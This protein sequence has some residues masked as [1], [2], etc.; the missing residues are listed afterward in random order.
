MYTDLLNIFLSS[1]SRM[2][3]FKILC[4]SK[5]HIFVICPKH[6]LLKE[7]NLPLIEK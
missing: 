2:L 1:I 7:C 5:T 4:I 6:Y 3:H